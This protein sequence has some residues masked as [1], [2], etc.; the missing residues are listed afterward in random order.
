MGEIPVVT[1]RCE[2]SPC[3]GSEF[4][5]S[6]RFEQA[7]KKVLVRDSARNPCNGVAFGTETYLLDGPLTWRMVAEFVGATEWGG[8]LSEEGLV[9]EPSIDGLL[10]WQREAVL[11]C[12]K[13]YGV[14]ETTLAEELLSLTD[15]CVRL[16][17]IY[18]GWQRV[19]D[20]LVRVSELRAELDLVDELAG[21]LARRYEI[22][23][24]AG[25]LPAIVGRLETEIE[26]RNR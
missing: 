3:P 7:G 4:I 10:H 16:S 21:D 15:R 25:C 11:I 13:R 17:L 8:G 9:G 19:V 14:N 6:V 5:N 12:W 20:D 2:C 24:D 18:S 26:T 23:D 1:L 22:A